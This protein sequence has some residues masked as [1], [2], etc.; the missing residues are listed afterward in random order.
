LQEQKERQEQQKIERAKRK[1]QRLKEIEERKQ[2]K[3][4]ERK[5]REENTPKLPQDEGL[6]VQKHGNKTLVY[7]K[8]GDNQ[9]S[10]QQT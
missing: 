3:L 9:G 4:E 1:E 6:I 8:K 2:R 7:K 10:Q 5:L